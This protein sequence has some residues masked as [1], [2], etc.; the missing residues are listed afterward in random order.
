MDG[1]WSPWSPTTAC[2][3]HCGPGIVAADRA[4]NAPKPSNGGDKCAGENTTMLLCENRQCLSKLKCV[5]DSQNIN[6]FTVIFNN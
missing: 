5:S 3:P 6:G 1:R 4:C 2:S